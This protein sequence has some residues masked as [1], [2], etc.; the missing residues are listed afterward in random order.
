MTVWK[1]VKNQ[2]KSGK[3]PDFPRKI[4]GNQPPDACTLRFPSSPPGKNSGLDTILSSFNYI[5]SFQNGC[6]IFDMISATQM[7]YAS[8]I[9]NGYNSIF[10]PQIYHTCE[11]SISYS[12]SVYII[13]RQ[14]YIIDKRRL[15]WYNLHE[16]RCYYVR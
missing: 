14:Q 4:L 7:I 6:Y 11:A 13:L 3:I 5:R 8:R 15:F 10:A 12:H 9:K 2:R 1:M 16:R